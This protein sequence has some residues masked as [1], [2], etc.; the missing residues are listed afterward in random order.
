M[1][2]GK[3][4]TEKFYNSLDKKDLDKLDKMGKEESLELIKAIY[5]KHYGSEPTGV[6][7]YLLKNRLTHVKT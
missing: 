6:L 2:L 1:Y 7:L 4:L 5:K 3:I